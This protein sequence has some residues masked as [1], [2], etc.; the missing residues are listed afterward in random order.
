MARRGLGTLILAGLAAFGYYKYSK[1]TD[2]QKRDL[3]EKGK[4]FV[5]ENLGGLKNVLGKKGETQQASG[6]YDQ[7]RNFDQNTYNQG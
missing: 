6:N 1:M 4:K 5:D 7:N 2:Q 3:K